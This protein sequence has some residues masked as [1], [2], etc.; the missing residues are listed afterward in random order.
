MEYYTRILEIWKDA[1][2]DL[3]ELLETKLRLEQLQ[4]M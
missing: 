4:A 1:D 2:P 3:P